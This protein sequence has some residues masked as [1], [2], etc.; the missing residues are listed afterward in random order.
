[1]HSE[2]VVSGIAIDEENTGDSE[3]VFIC[4]N[5]AL[6]HGFFVSF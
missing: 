3:T 2:N 1:M 5:P 4:F 6:P